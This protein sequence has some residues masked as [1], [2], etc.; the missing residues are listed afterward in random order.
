MKKLITRAVAV[1]V[2]AGAFAVA[3]SGL[4]HA[5]TGDSS[6]APAPA[7]AADAASGATQ[8]QL[9]KGLP[10]VPLADPTLGAGTVLPPV[11]DVLGAL[12]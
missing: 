10:P 6:A 2:G 3:A 7:P 5:D 1:T 9:I 8:A 12:G 4:A 11:F